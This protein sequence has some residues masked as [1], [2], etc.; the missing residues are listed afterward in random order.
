MNISY[1][2]ILNPEATDWVVFVHGFGGSKRMWKKQTIPMQEQ[3]NI[4][5][6]DLPGHGESILE[7]KES[8]DVISDTASSILDLMKGLG[9]EKAHFVGVSLGTII[10]LVIG[11]MAPEVVTDM[12]LGGAV[13]GMNILG[14]ILLKTA[15]IAR[16]FMPYMWLYKIMAKIIMPHQGSKASRIIFVR[17]ARKLGRGT[18][19]FWIDA[20]VSGMKTLQMCFEKLNEIPKLCIM[21]E[22]DTVFLNIL[23]S[24]IDKYKNMLLNTIEN[25]GHVCNLEKP[26]IFNQIA[27]EFMATHTGNEL[28]YSY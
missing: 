7:V 8:N 16:R 24:N 14:S 5:N 6:L 21:G 22:N 15:G 12:V 17:E 10:I 19:N 1:E 27:I 13:I 2:T 26:K 9:I 18:F 11:I 28:Q 4:L 25:C 20:M 3:Y 23:Y